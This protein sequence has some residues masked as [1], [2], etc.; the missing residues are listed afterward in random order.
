M[1]SEEISGT[2]GREEKLYEKNI[3]YLSP[4]RTMLLSLSRL[5]ENFKSKADVEEHTVQSD[6]TYRKAPQFQIKASDKSGAEEC[7]LTGG[8]EGG[9]YDQKSLH[10]I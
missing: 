8:R 1:A 6:I 3:L 4:K 9:K 10:I 7:H 2:E 5:W